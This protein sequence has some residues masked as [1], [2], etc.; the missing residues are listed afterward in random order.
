[1]AKHGRTQRRTIQR[2]RRIAEGQ[3]AELAAARATLLD[4]GGL[5][6]TSE[7][8]HLRAEVAALK[9]AGLAVLEAYLASRGIAVPLQSLAALVKA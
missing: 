5:Q 8:E 7:A 1:M 4:V 9:A 6:W 2:W 3:A